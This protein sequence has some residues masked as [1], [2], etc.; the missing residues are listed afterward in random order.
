MG[1]TPTPPT[2]PMPTPGAELSAEDIAWARELAAA[3]IT[4]ALEVAGNDDQQAEPLYAAARSHALSV[5]TDDSLG[6]ER[7]LATMF[8]ISAHAVSVLRDLSAVDGRPAGDLWRSRLLHRLDG[9]T[10]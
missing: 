6:A 1:T 9:P 2:P 4:T 5:R 7:W 10:D 3:M 8:F